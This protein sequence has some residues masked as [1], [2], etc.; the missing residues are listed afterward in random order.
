MFPFILNII[1]I[2]SYT[3]STLYL[4]RYSVLK[5]KRSIYKIKQK[6]SNMNITDTLSAWC[7]LLKLHGNDDAEATISFN[8]WVFCMQNGLDCT[9]PKLIQTVCRELHTQLYGYIK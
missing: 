7:Y 9:L 2:S 8:H 6:E 3:F 4:K 5:I 1:F